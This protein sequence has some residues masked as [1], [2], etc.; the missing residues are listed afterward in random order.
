MIY[1]ATNN[2]ENRSQIFDWL[3]FC[4]LTGDKVIV[5]L[6]DLLRSG[7]RFEVQ[8]GWQ[9]VETESEGSTSWSSW[10]ERSPVSPGDLRHDHH[11]QDNDLRE[12]HTNLIGVIV[13]TTVQES[14]TANQTPDSHGELDET[15]KNCDFWKVDNVHWQRRWD[16]IRV[17]HFRQCIEQ[18]LQEE[19]A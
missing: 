18:R 14:E 3:L 19:T 1:G 7:S 4:N 13:G 9:Q 15:D 2:S 10:G 8:K 12:S 5:V 11:Q 17:D 6:R 16:P